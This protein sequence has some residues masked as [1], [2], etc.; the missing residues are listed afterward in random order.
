[1]T[2]ARVGAGTAE[3]VLVCDDDPVIRRVLRDA[4]EAAGATVAEAGD[5]DECVAVA[6]RYRPD[7]VVIDVVMPG[8]DGFSALP[9]L[10]AGFPAA[11]L[12]TLT[13]FPAAEI[14]DRSR[15]LG[16]EACLDKVG[17]LTAIDGLV[18]RYARSAA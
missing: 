16:A 17:V 3:R 5:G 8:A 2:P 18:G 11:R 13:A 9:R 7:V 6:E 14:S 15:L 12:V 10:R 4:F 1:A